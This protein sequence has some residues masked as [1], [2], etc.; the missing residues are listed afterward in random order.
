[1]SA[2][3]KH[4]QETANGT[5]WYM[6]VKTL[7]ITA[8]ALAAAILAVL[9]LGQMLAPQPGPTKGPDP[10][11]SASIASVEQ[12]GLTRLGD[13]GEE[14]GTDV[15]LPLPDAAGTQ[16]NNARLVVQRP[17]DDDTPPTKKPQER[18]PV[19]DP[20]P[21]LTP[22]STPTS[23]PTPTPTPTWVARMPA[24]EDFLRQVADQPVWGDYAPETP[25][26]IARIVHTGTTTEEGNPIP[27]AQAAKEILE[28]LEDVELADTPAGMDAIG[29]T[30]AVGLDI[31]GLAQQPLLLTWSLD[32]PGVSDEWKVENFAYRIIATGDRDTGSVKIWVPDLKGPGPYSVNVELIHASDGANADIASPYV[33]S[34]D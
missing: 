8:G 11:D 13:F 9:Q 23:T 20:T 18:A 22:T 12:L 31:R 7:V 3:P 6:R 14:I 4:G 10:I 5:P 26:K 2:D 27:P 21:S 16:G 17:D 1:M 24:P 34:E 28:A 30:V 29:W 15:Y 25:K 32:G 19:P 33:I